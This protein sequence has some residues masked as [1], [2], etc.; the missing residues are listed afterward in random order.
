MAVPAAIDAAKYAAA[1]RRELIERLGLGDLGS[2]ADADGDAGASD[3]GPGD[4][5]AAPPDGGLRGLESELDEFASN[6]VIKAVLD[7]GAP[8]REYARDIEDRLRGAELESIA[9]YVAE[10]GAL[11]ALHGQARMRGGRDV[12]KPWASEEGRGDH[13]QRGLLVWLQHMQDPWTPQL[14]PCHSNLALHKKN[15]AQMTACDAIL[16]HMEGLLGRFQSDLGRASDEIRALQAQSAA[17]S[18]RL[19]NRRAVES[20]LGSFIEAVAVP[21]ELVQGIMEAEVGGTGAGHRRAGQAM[22]RP[23]A[24]FA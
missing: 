22:G 17:M 15:L 12:H 3:A 13:L 4:F 19:R 10:S 20:R 9:D 5:G 21:E 7:A 14:T 1:L 24:P 16:E 18:T 2:D 8:P 23:V 6:D 11:V